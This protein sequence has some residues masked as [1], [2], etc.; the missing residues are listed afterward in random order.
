MAVC[1]LGGCC[2]AGLVSVPADA[3]QQLPPV[4]YTAIDGHTEVLVPWQGTNVSVLVEQ[5]PVRDPLVMNAMV[6]AFD[7]AFSY[8]AATTG[9]LPVVGHSLNGRDEIAEVTSTC[10][11]GCTYIGATGT[12]ILT[13]Y[14]ENMYQEIASGNQYDQIHVL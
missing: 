12:E 14:F 10:G 9:R 8:Y 13:S 3:A 1:S 5:G 4:T 7:A 2:R 6:G 11:A